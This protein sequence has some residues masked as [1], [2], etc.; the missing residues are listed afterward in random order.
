M[1]KTT[2]ALMNMF[3]AVNWQWWVPTLTDYYHV[4]IQLVLMFAVDG[5]NN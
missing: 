5:I 3:A 4:V 2:N 1:S